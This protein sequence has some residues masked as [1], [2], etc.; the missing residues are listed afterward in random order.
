[1]AFIV[2][3]LRELKIVT[4]INIKKLIG[5]KKVMRGRPSQC[6]KGKTRGHRPLGWISLQRISYKE[7]LY[8]ALYLL[9]LLLS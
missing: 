6:E 9:S 1:M 2:S 4:S 5:D 8:E 3:I 7:I